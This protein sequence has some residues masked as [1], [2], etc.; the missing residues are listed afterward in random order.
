[1]RNFNKQ[2][3]KNNKT[4]KSLDDQGAKTFKEM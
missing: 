4:K 1:M 2:M 3:S